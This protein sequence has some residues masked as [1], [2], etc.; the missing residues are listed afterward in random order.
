MSWER[1]GGGLWVRDVGVTELINHFD[2]EKYI[3]D[4]GC[5]TI[6]DI[7][8]CADEIR[9]CRDSFEYAARNY[10]WI[11]NKARQD[12]LFA[13]NEGQDLLLEKIYFLRD[14][15]KPQKIM[16]IKAR[17]LGCSTLIEGLIAW[18]SMFF[19]NIAAM[20]VSHVGTHA[21]FLFQKMV[22]IYDHLPWWMKPML[23]SRKEEEG[24]IFRNPDPDARRTDPG[25]NSTVLVQAATQVSGVGEGYT[26]NALHFSE[27]CAVEDWK[28]REIIDG[29]MV[30]ALAP[31]VGTFAILESTAKG[32]GRY[33]ED[34]WVAN[35]DLAEKADWLPVF[36]PWF[37][38][39]G[40]VMAPEN[41]WR[42]GEQEE[43]MR[44]RVENEW[45]C[46]TNCGEFRE[47][48]FK[49]FDI[50]HSQC[51]NCNKGT[52]EP[53]VLN[54][55]QLAWMQER[56]L[57]AR[58]RG[59]ESLKELKQELCTTAEEAFQISGIA[60]FPEDTQEF[61]NDCVCNPL[62]VGNLD[63]KGRFH[64][65]VRTET[66]DGEEHFRCFQEWCTV[67]HRWDYDNP[68]QIWELPEEGSTYTI[69]VDI[70]EGLATEKSDYSVAW[71]NRIGRAPA[72][73]VHVATYRSNSINPSN[74]AGVVVNLGNWY[75]EAMLA[76]EYNIYQTTGDLVKNFYVYPNI[77]RWKHYDSVR[78]MESNKYH[79]ITQQNSKPQLWQ[80]GV[81]ALRSKSWY[82]HDR[83][84]A[85]EMKRF[86]KD[87][88][89]SKKAEAET[90]FHDDVI[91]AS[92]ICRYTSHDLDYFDEAASNPIPQTGAA[93]VS[94]MDWIQDC[95][96]CK[97]MWPTMNPEE[98]RRCPSC[99]SIMLH[100]KPTV[101]NKPQKLTAESVFED[102]AKELD[103]LDTLPEPVAQIGETWLPNSRVL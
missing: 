29:D 36:L 73:D 81:M 3:Q 28:A 83:M 9:R 42:P 5:M 21:T 16:I 65:A 49:K 55:G 31:N 82:I 62:Y 24:L 32:A 4:P 64:C 46:C 96:R 35:L 20:V 103:E 76:I 6:A 68:L 97:H 75:N 95:L 99:G 2:Q 70:S 84:F 44:T 53:Y 45:L 66:D 14:R 37:F 58:R 79:W 91:M 72:P 40:R 69:G 59:P 34:L 67:D 7:R 47:R 30:H 12:Q 93:W 51:T 41:G 38:E 48:F 80:T 63:S 61:V 22:H 17:Q 43:A 71:I 39:K 27:Y 77:F 50:S 26:I 92:L 57:N 100:A 89:D 74:L 85:Y 98:T 52:R 8:Q 25:L 13:L 10:F 90:N 94:S 15:G 88:Y 18:R 101:S 60:V 102:M 87:D 19:P 54:D 78:G 23:A 1:S 11:V 33:S 56:S 86:Q